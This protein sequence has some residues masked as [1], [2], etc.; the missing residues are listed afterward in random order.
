[1]VFKCSVARYPTST[2]SLKEHAFTGTYNNIWGFTYPF[3]L[4]FTGVD[5]LTHS[6]SSLLRFI[7]FA[8]L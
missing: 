2:L 4:N 3:F 8:K 7:P 6:F 1:M 5:C